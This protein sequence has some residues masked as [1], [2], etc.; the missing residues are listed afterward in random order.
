MKNRQSGYTLIELTIVLGVVAFLGTMAFNELKQDKIEGEAKKQA[1]RIVEVF[2]KASER[3]Q[4]QAKNTG[5]I[6]PSNFPSS[7]QVLVNEGYLQNCTPTEAS[8]GDCR[9]M[10]ETLW[11]D[12]IS[13]RAYGVGG[14]PTIPRFELTTP[15]DKVPASYRDNIAGELL[16]ILPFAKVSGTSIVAEIGR[17]G[18]EI[19]H[20]NFYLLDGSRPLTGTMKAAGNAIEDVKDISIA[21]LTNRTV[22]SGLGWS[23]VQQNSQ[24]VPVVNCP[25]TRTNRKINVIPLS[26]NK[27]G[28]PFNKIGAVEGRVDEVSPGRFVAYVRVWETNADGTQGWYVPSPAN[29]TVLVQQQCTK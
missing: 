13:V 21:G 27:N 1:A 28:Y 23:S 17:P 19:A 24:T 7:V 3:Y 15:L 4:V 6:A 8:V 26:Y 9:P 18:T 20:D 2:T 5:I 11:G 25:S 16:S 29:G 10:T 14:N 22:L 12:T